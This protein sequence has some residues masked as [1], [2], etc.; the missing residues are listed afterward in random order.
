MIKV[1]HLS[2]SMVRGGAEVLL[3]DIIKNASFRDFDITFVATSSGELENELESNK[4]NYFKII[5]KYPI[6]IKTI[7]KL[8]R[9]IKRHE[10]QIVHSHQAV[11]AIHAYFATIGLNVKNVMSIHGISKKNKDLIV[12]RFLKSKLHA[13]I[14][15]S[16]SFKLKLMNNSAY[17][18]T[19][20]LNVIYNGID[21]NRFSLKIP[22]IPCNKKTIIVGTVG[23][24]REEKDQL[25]LC[26]AIPYVINKIKNIKF[27]FVGGV[28]NDN[29]NYLN[30]CKKYCEEN[31]LLPYVTFLGKRSDIAEI[32]KGLDV[33]VFPSI[34]E[35]FGI[36][37]IEA[38]A[39][40]VPT[41]LS[42]IP[43]FMEISCNGENSVVFNVMDHIDLSEKI[44]ELIGNDGLKNRIKN[45]AFQYVYQNFSIQ[46]HLK[47]LL[48]LYNDVLF[49]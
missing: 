38:M 13:I 42:N 10:I 43:P 3:F 5:R 14:L 36:A 1:L 17:K 21:F 8:R 12:I 32:L 18:L 46:S 49:N 29:Y 9:I 30:K 37:A 40:K 15:P 16:N 47:N 23:N 27:I 26:K 20:N 11:S 4:I 35:S 25:T 7:F 24:F 2:D 41:I 31:N 6:D 39:I 44:I 45:S 28:V 33:F 22:L 48:K 19:R 34:Q